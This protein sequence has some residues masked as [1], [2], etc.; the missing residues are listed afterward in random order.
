LEKLKAKLI[1][2]GRVIMSEL[3]GLKHDRSL[4]L[5]GGLAIMLSA[6]QELKI[7]AMAPGEGAL[8]VGVLY[9]LLG[10]D[11]DHDK[12]HETVRQFIKRY[13]VD[14]NQSE[15]VRRIALD[16]FKQLGLEDTPENQELER[17][18]GWAADLH[19][20]GLSIAHD[21]YHKHGAYILEHADM[22]GFSN[23]DQLL[24]A[25]LVLG[26]QGKMSK[27]RG[28]DITRATWRALLCLRLAV[29][30]SRRRENQERVPVSLRTDGHLV[31]ARVDKAWLEARP[32]SEF[33]LK[34]EEKEWRKVGTLF[35]LKQD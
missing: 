5:A 18:L 31:E 30:L 9:D 28:L 12:R 16:F 21:D 26:H 33:L 19:E 14:T 25:R 10:R 11:S 34:S 32:L 1:Q 15:R 7:K 4:V 24:L 35:R 2:D 3:P 6:F 22:P 8:R 13:H 29:L 20:V 27:L 23:D 17:A